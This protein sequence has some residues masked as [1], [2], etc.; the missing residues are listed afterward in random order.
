[1]NTKTRVHQLKLSYTMLVENLRSYENVKGVAESLNLRH[2]NSL[3][4]FHTQVVPI[5]EQ[6]HFG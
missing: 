6:M 2:A 3:F 5:L 4:D 1:M